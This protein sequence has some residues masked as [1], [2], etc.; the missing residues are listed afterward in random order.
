MLKPVRARGIGDLFAGRAVLGQ[1]EY[2]LMVTYKVDPAGRPP[3]A[4]L[5]GTIKPLGWSVAKVPANYLVLTLNHN[6][7]FKVV[8]VGGY[9]RLTR[10]CKIRGVAVVLPGT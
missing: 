7:T 5:E 4:V 9:N 1:V 8:R 10:S 2:D 3:A 6:R